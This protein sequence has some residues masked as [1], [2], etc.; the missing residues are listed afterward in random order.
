MKMISKAALI[1]ACVAAQPAF[2][3]TTFGIYGDSATQA[4]AVAQ[5]GG[6]SASVLANLT[7]GSLAGVNVLWVLNGDNGAQNNGLV[8]NTAAVADFV[9]GGGVLVYNDR[10]VPGAGSVLPGSAGVSFVQEYTANID[11]QT[12]GTPLTNGLTNSTL[13]GGNSSAHGYIDGATLPAG[14]VGLLND[15]TSGHLVDSYY[16]YGAG[17]VYFSG[18]PLDYYLGGNGSVAAFRTTYA[19]NLVTEAAAL[20]TPAVP[21]PASW[22]MMI[23]GFGAVGFAMRRRQ[24][25]A[26][27]IAFA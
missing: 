21:E 13:D 18:V 24:R 26:T 27:R 6:Y 2:A 8:T 9:R 3:A 19:T 23:A 1:A 17:K 11:V 12:P 25:V 22:A 4:Q 20:A 14:G 5:A 7:A 15:G 10:S 16:S